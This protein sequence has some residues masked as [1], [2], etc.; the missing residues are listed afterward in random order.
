LGRVV[1]ESL[2]GTFAITAKSCALPLPRGT[3]E[4]PAPWDL[5]RSIV[6]DLVGLKLTWRQC[7]CLWA[8]LDLTPTGSHMGMQMCFA[9]KVPIQSQT[10][11]AYGC[12]FLHARRENV[13]FGL[14]L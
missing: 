11:S 4:L 2:L 14:A 3:A 12:A 13:R 1:R 10:D 9:L 5:S 7:H 6:E 8:F